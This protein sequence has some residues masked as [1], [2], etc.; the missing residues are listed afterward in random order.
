MPSRGFLVRKDF[1]ALITALSDMGMQ[2]LGPT[3]KHG[4]IVYAPLT[5]SA[6][7]PQG[8][9]DRQSPGHYR[10]E[11]QNHP[12][13][14]NWA[15]G[16]QALKPIVFYPDESLWRVE[17]NDKGRLQFSTTLPE[18]RPTAVI[19]VRACDIAALAVQ[20]QHF[21]NNAHHD[22]HYARRRESLFH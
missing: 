16:P 5:S 6:D 12:R 14:F 21:L 13:C 20:D 22:E 17:R 11:K 19:G 18:V 4:A 15:N 10:I 2:C 9:A 8:V 1:D 7:L 3:V